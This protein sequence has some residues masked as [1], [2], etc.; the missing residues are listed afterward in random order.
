MLV[1][2]VI[3]GEIL[4]FGDCDLDRYDFVCEGVR[5]FCCVVLFDA[6]VGVWF[7]LEIGLLVDEW[8][9][10]LFVGGVGFCLLE[11]G[12]Y[13]ID[14][15]VFRQL[16]VLGRVVVSM[17]G[18]FDCSC[19]PCGVGDELWFVYLVDS[20]MWCGYV[21]YC[22]RG[23]FDFAWWEV[24]L[25]ALFNGCLDFQCV[26]LCWDFLLDVGDGDFGLL[27]LVGEDGVEMAN[28][29]VVVLFDELC[30]CW[31]WLLMV[32]LVVV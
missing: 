20:G 22:E 21:L 30:A 13:E 1:Y 14:I 26:R 25:V 29:V 17:S 2:D 9:D 31:W 4:W 32:V 23:A 7:D 12:F 10:N 19:W 27:F 24:D 15:M 18:A 28:F 5:V 8:I 3:R 16:V 11:I 6:I